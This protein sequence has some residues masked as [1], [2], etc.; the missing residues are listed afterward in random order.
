MDFLV[1]DVGDVLLMTRPGKQYEALARLAN[2][3]PRDV[4][5]RFQ[6]TDINGAFDRGLLNPQEF[7]ES[8]SRL[9]ECQLGIEAAKH[10]WRAVIGKI[11]VEMARAVR[12]L[13]RQERLLLASNTDTIH[14]PIVHNRLAA[15]GIVAPAVLSF[16]LG[17]TKPSA[18]FFK[19]IM[20]K[21]HV[22]P[23]QA[24][25]IDDQAINVEAAREAGFQGIVHTTVASTT[26]WIKNA[27][28]EIDESK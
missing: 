25:F 27:I 7:A 5:D 24:G 3:S 14:W 26:Q 10:A 9:L 16:K 12:P 19:V 18:D 6:S 11:D 1:I 21:Y 20:R 8:V 15:A 23:G 17:I 22:T 2:L 13:A 28:P 4:T